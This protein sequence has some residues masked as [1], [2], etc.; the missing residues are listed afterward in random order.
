MVRLTILAAVL[1]FNAGVCLAQN[2]EGST[3]TRDNTVASVVA[4]GFRALG[5][6]STATAERVS[7]VVARGPNQVLDTML[8]SALIAG[9]WVTGFDWFTQKQVEAIV[10]LPV[11]LTGHGMKAVYLVNGGVSEVKPGAFVATILN[12]PLPDG[13]KFTVRS[14]DGA[15]VGSVLAVRRFPVVGGDNATA[16]IAYE[17]VFEAERFDDES[18]YLDIAYAGR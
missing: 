15:S 13:Y 3:S 16:Y 4:A 2:V 8:R 11:E 17:V 9:G 7:A 14:K 5:Y 1:V 6:D 10:H 12:G 18:M